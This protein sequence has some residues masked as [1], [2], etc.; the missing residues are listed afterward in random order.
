MLLH[1][2]RDH[3][4]KVE[5]LLVG[6]MIRDHLAQEPRFVNIDQLLCINQEANVDKSVQVARMCK[7]YQKA[8]RV[9]AFLGFSL[10]IRVTLSTIRMI[11]A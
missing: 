7:I 8:T 6:P 3:P 4:C 11:K 1:W 5:Y 9:L 2:D 10:S